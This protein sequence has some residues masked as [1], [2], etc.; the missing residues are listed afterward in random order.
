MAGRYRLWHP[1]ALVAYHFRHLA[2]GVPGRRIDAVQCAGHAEVTAARLPVGELFLLGDH[3]RYALGW[4]RLPGE[5]GGPV[6]VIMR[7]SRGFQRVWMDFPLTEDGWRVAWQSLAAL[8]LSA[9]E[10]LADEFA[11][12]VPTAPPATSGNTSG[13]PSS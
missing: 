12:Q 3:G 4:Q 9:A 10:R 11:G 5:T 8:D 2:W 13:S 7:R 6:F 1:A